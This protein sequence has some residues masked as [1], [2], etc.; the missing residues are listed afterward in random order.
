[1]KANEDCRACLSRLVR[2]AAER[3]TEDPVLR[4][5]AI[6]ERLKLLDSEFSLEKTSISVSTKLHRVVTTVTGNTDP[7]RQ[8]KDTEVKMAKELLK[9]QQSKPLRDLRSCLKF[10]VRGNA[11]DF[12]IDQKTIVKVPHIYSSHWHPDSRQK[13]TQ[14]QELRDNPKRGLAISCF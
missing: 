7:Y 9:T 13:W 8:M 4:A 14:L 11:I 1:M 6:E 2:Q 12:F 3:A 10:A 5:K